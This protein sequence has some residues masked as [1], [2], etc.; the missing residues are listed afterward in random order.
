VSFV[1]HAP[2]EATV[3]EM[4]RLRCLCF[5]RHSQRYAASGTMPH[6]EFVRL[7]PICEKRVFA[8]RLALQCGIIGMT[9]T[10]L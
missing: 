9:V 8:K 1:G 4:E 6:R 2:L 10:G 5:M 3:F 7:R